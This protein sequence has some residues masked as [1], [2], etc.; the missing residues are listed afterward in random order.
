MKRACLNHVDDSTIV[1]DPENCRALV[2]EDDPIL[3]QLLKDLLLFSGYEVQLV[4]T[5]QAALQ[6][7]QRW[8]PH[9]I[10]VDLR[11]P[12]LDG[13]DVI[14]QIRQTDRS[15][16]TIVG[17]SAYGLKQSRDSAIAAGCDDFVAKP[18]LI[19]T[20]LEKLGQNSCSLRQV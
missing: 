1:G 20:L 3:G 2:V 11:L 17:I 15:P 14:R 9:I 4:A 12:D 5:G 16:T 19:E 13:C 8:Q 6:Q 18:F 7:W 10:L